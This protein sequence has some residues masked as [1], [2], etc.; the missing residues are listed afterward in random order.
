MD[1]IPIGEINR[2]FEDED[3]EYSF[4]LELSNDFYDPYKL[5]LALFQICRINIPPTDDEVPIHKMDPAIDQS[6]LIRERQGV[7]LDDFEKDRINKLFTCLSTVCDP[8]TQPWDIG[9]NNILSLDFVSDVVIGAMGS[10]YTKLGVDDG[11][12]LPHFEMAFDVATIIEK[13]LHVL[14]CDDE[15]ILQSIRNDDVNWEK[16]L[17][18]WLPHKSLSSMIHIASDFHHLMLLYTMVV[19]CFLIIQK[20]Y[21]NSSKSN[22]CLNPFLRLFL[23]VWKNMTRVIFLGIEI[24]RRDEEHNFPGYPEVIRYMIKGSS[25][26]RSVISLILNDDFNKREHDLKHEPLL[27]F[28]HPYGRKFRDGS[29]K[30]DMRVFVAALLALGSDLEDVIEL[31]FNFEPEDEYDEDIKYMFEMELENMEEFERIDTNNGKPVGE[32]EYHKRHSER[33]NQYL[34]I[35]RDDSTP[36]VRSLRSWEVHPD[37]ECIFDSDDEEEEE[38]EEGEGETQ[39]NDFDSTLTQEEIENE[40]NAGSNDIDNSKKFE[41]KI[42]LMESVKNGRIDFTDGLYAIRNSVSKRFEIDSDGRDWRDIPRGENRKLDSKFIE[43]LKQSQSDSDIFITP[44]S[45]LIDSIKTL[46]TDTQQSSICEKIIQSIAWVVQYEYE[47]SIMTAEERSSNS[48][49]TINTDVIYEFLK[50][51][52]NFELMMKYNPSATFSIVD[53]LMM[54]EGYKRVLIWFIT[55]SSLNQWL[56]NYFYELL[57]GLRGNPPSEENEDNTIG[58]RF[59]FSR[60]G[61]LVLSDMEK[62]MLLHEFFSNAVIYLSRGSSFEFE[63]LISNEEKQVD[64]SANDESTFITNRFNAQKLIKVICLVLKSLQ[65]KG[66][67]KVNDPEY[68]VEIQTLLMQWVGAGSVPEAKELFNEAGVIEQQIKIKSHNNEFIEYDDKFINNSNV[69]AISTKIISEQVPQRSSLE[70]STLSP[71]Q[72]TLKQMDGLKLYRLFQ[73]TL[74]VDTLELLT[75][76]LHL[77]AHYELKKDEIISFTK[78]LNSV[79]K[80]YPEKEVT[81]ICE[82]V[83]TSIGSNIETGNEENVVEIA[84]AAGIVSPKASTV[85]VRKVVNEY[86]QGE[87]EFDTGGNNEDNDSENEDED[88]RGEKKKKKNKKKKK[89]KT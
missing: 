39:E 64:L 1:D 63:D 14:N 62:S 68:R 10:S 80:V 54:V 12:S 5:H 27:N 87:V 9:E 52:D 75:T 57:A 37:C 50:H 53:E 88:G 60:V 56:I 76:I 49:P 44:M 66:I 61:P 16:D 8:Y 38:E 35:E 33:I 7:Y 28:M 82:L 70:T 89:R 69:H 83:F 26:V 32:D 34:G 74:S 43:L 42:D 22:I 78:D 58:L 47:A 24:D 79:E 40:D 13:I 31:L 19:V 85:W 30:T 15:N 67:L 11:Y 17:D 51:E 71:F 46:T 25:A 55:H 48:D 18:K 73:H 6:I 72:E 41:K 2:P 4:D 86:M 29:I 21:E 59:S 20:L 77:G 65:S 84:F 36:I 23:Q 3:R 81:N 45:S